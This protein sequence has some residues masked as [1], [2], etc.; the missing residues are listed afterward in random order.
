MIN[1]VVVSNIFYFHPNL[2]KWSN[3]TNVFQMGWNHQPVNYPFRFCFFFFFVLAAW[4]NDVSAKMDSEFRKQRTT[5]NSLCLPLPSARCQ[6]GKL[7]TLQMEGPLSHYRSWAR[8]GCLV[9][10]RMPL[11]RIITLGWYF[12]HMVTI[13][14]G[15]A[16]LRSICSVICVF[17]HPW[18]WRWKI[19]TIHGSVQES[20]SLL[21]DFYQR[22]VP[23]MEVLTNMLC[24]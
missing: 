19:G 13:W 3:L 7:E 18:I 11:G 4:N 14:A 24:K 16:M 1:W 17:F 2:G 15:N 8:F 10:G 23:P 21:A 20:L 9:G 5:K 22:L 12:L 6:K